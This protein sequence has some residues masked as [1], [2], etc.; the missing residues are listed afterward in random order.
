MVAI[1]ED[2]DTDS[3]DENLA[4]IREA[5]DSKILT[6]SLYTAPKVAEQVKERSDFIPEA[7][8]SLAQDTKNMLAKHALQPTRS[9]IEVPP[10]S[11]RR[12]KEEDGIRSQVQSDLEVTPQFQTFVAARLS[13]MLEDQMIEEAPDLEM[14]NKMTEICG[15]DQIAET[16]LG[17][18]TE[19]E[20]S[21]GNIKLLSSSQ[22]EL[23]GEVEKAVLKQVRPDILPSH[24]R[25]QGSPEGCAVTGE[26]V[27]SQVEV[28]GWVNKFANR[29]EVGESRIKRKK[30][31][32]KKKKKKDEIQNTDTVESIET[33]M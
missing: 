28:Q 1:V 14:L 8:S 33:N 25:V 21:G 4:N 27:R 29:V 10:L 17:L 24:R 30:K 19:T 3:E 9:R 22:T 26:F 18:S 16:A 7:K 12:D 11:L 5:L 20:K 23:L 6:E 13:E 31:K 32:V 15:E 2:S